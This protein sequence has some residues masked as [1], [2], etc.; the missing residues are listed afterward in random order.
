[1]TSSHYVKMCKKKDAIEDEALKLAT[2]NIKMAE[3]L[4]GDLQV[5]Q[6][7]VHPLFEENREK[8]THLIEQV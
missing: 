8:A 7:T 4:Q 6:E 5:Y 2:E 3:D 1:M